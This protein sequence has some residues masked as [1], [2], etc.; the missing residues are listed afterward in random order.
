VSA[1]GSLHILARHRI[2][3]Q[4]LEVFVNG[5]VCKLVIQ[6][7]V[8]VLIDEI[9]TSSNATVVTARVLKEN[10]RLLTS[11][12]HTLNLAVED[13]SQISDAPVDNS[14]TIAINRSNTAVPCHGIGLSC[15]RQCGNKTLISYRVDPKSP[16]IPLCWRHKQQILNFQV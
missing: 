1:V 13:T 3:T 12:L 4:E 16:W 11:A 10:V 6:D 5:R 8:H 9:N 15:N 14:S 2:C 7:P